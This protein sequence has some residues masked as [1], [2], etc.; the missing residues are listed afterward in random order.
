L[1]AVQ[2]LAVDPVPAFVDQAVLVRATSAAGKAAPGLEVTVEFPDGARRALGATDTQ[3]V[4]SFTA[5]AVGPHVFSA[6]IGGVRCVASVAFRAA[7]KTWMLAIVCLP[8]GLALLWVHA[9][10]LFARSRSIAPN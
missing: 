3:G 1:F 5:E 6:T 10:R 4:V 8:L 2:Q 7:H 9:R